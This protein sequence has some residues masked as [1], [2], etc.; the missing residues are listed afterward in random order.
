MPTTAKAVNIDSADNGP[1]ADKLRLA[2]SK[3][4]AFNVCGQPY[5]AVGDGTTDDRAAIAAADAACVAFGGGYVD[6]PAGVF[7]VASD[8]TITSTCRFAPGSRIQRDNTVNVILN[9]KAPVASLG[10]IF[11][12][13]AS[14]AVSFGASMLERVYPQWW[15]AVADGTT[16]DSGPCQAAINSISSVSPADFGGIVFFATPTAAGASYY[17]GTTGLVVQSRGVVLQ[18]ETAYTVIKYAGTGTGVS[19]ASYTAGA[20]LLISGAKDLYVQCTNAAANA[21]NFAVPRYVS[22]DHCFAEMTTGGATGSGFTFD[23]TLGFGANNVLNHCRSS[24]FFKGFVLKSTSGNGANISIDVEINFCFVSGAVAAVG[25]GVVGFEFQGSGGCTVRGG[26]CEIVDTGVK[27]VSSPTPCRGVNIANLRMESI[28]NY[29]YDIP[30]DSLETTVDGSHWGNQVWRDLSPDTVTFHT[31]SS[32]V[33]SLRLNVVKPT[34]VNGVNGV[35]SLATSSTG[36]AS[37]VEIGGPSAAFSVTGFS[38]PS[39]NGPTNADY[40]QLH[41]HYLGAQAITFVDTD[42]TAN[43]ANASIRTSGRGNVTIAGSAG[44]VWADFEYLASWSQWMLKAHS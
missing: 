24:G 29:N 1:L 8:I 2:F 20:Q 42:A 16:D 34:L 44:G 36:Y 3:L 11:N 17:I 5:N 27:L 14:G 9:G 32:R 28:N 19:F 18:G 15:G 40:A 4:N 6:F 39:F 35:I 26:G 10:Q 43:A 41:V 22:V 30:A 33:G 31:T 12:V 25:T 7:R 37:A 23:T 38:V 13:T 21:W